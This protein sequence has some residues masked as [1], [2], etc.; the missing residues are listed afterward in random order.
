MEEIAITEIPGFLLGHAQNREAGT[1]CTVILCPEG[2]VAGA[3]VRGGSPGT[4]DTDALDPVNNRKVIHGVL[5]SGGS[6]FGLDAAGGV[7][8]YLEERGIGRD[9]GVTY[10]PNVCAAILFDLKCG[11]AAVRPDAAMGYEAC[12]SAGAAPFPDGN[13]GAGTGATVGKILGHNHAMK[14]GIGSFAWREGELTVGA[15]VAVNCVGDVYDRAEGRLIAG[16]RGADGRTLIGSEEIIVSQYADRADFYSGNTVLGCVVTNA[17]LS[18]AQAKKLASVA[19]NGIAR[20]VSPA[21]SVY[22]GDTVF[23]MCAGQVDAALDAVAILAA[24]AVEQAILR[25]VRAAEAAY[26]HPACRDL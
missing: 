4:R 23:A 22:D 6:A 10:V 16:V 19:Q 5:L 11:S 7:M 21:H 24:R 26:G 15:V 17:R 18:K 14:G 1:G 25:A 20:A 8:R 3:D 12:R 2:A 9:V 13:H